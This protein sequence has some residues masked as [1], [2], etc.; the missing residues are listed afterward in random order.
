[1]KSRKPRA[2][3]ILTFHSLY[4]IFDF[5]NCELIL[6]P[7]TSHKE[8]V[9]SLKHIL[10]HHP[11]KGNPHQTLGDSSSKTLLLWF[12][13]ERNQPHL[14][15]PNPRDSDVF[16]EEV[17]KLIRARLPEFT[18]W[19][20]MLVRASFETICRDILFWLVENDGKTLKYSVNK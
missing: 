19:Y 15:L 10:L 2:S 5:R 12:A 9:M 6:H 18:D 11:F 13:Q 7:N 4:T 20:N 8:S 17:G 3:V 14:P 16:L 1:M